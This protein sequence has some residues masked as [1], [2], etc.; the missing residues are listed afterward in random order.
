MLLYGQ[1]LSLE[2]S[3]GLRIRSNVNW[4][5]NNTTIDTLSFLGHLLTIQYSLNPLTLSRMYLNYMYNLIH[6]LDKN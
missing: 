2:K 1:M 6:N 3:P 4:V 5:Q